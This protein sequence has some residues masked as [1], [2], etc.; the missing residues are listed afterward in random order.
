MNVSEWVIILTFVFLKISWKESILTAEEKLFSNE[1][2]FVGKFFG[3]IILFLLIAPGLIG[4]EGAKT[5]IA[6]LILWVFLWIG[7]PILGPV[8]YTHLTLPTTPYV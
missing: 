6:P 7:I 3:F 2:T 1:Q 8:S 5:S 4:G